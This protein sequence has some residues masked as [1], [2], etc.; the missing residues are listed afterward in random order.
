MRAARLTR[1]LI[2][3]ALF[4]GA[5][6]LRVY[7]LDAVPLRGDEAFSVRYWAVPPEE[8]VRTMI[9]RDHE[10][11]P[12][13]T[14]LTFWAWKYAA[15]QSPFAMR[16]LPAL[17]SLVGMAGAA[18]LARQLTRNDRVGWI[19]AALW[20]IHPFEIWHAQDVRNYAV[21]AGA[22]ALALA[23]FVRAVRRRQR[24]DWVF[25]VA[26]EWLALNTF[27]LEAF[28]LP[29]QAL[30]LLLFRRSRRVW[31]QAA[32][33]WAALGILLIPWSAQIATLTGSGYEGTAEK[34]DLSH[35]VTRFLPEL[36]IGSA[37]RAPWGILLS[38]AWIVVIA[39]LWLRGND[40]HRLGLWLAGAI[41]IPA[42]LLAVTATRMSVF[43]PRYVIP[44]I[45]ALLLLTAV[46][47]APDRQSMPARRDLSAARLALIALPV[48]CA[49]VLLPYYRGD[50]PKSPD[51]PA[52]T[53][54]LEERAMPRDLILQAAAD[55]AF[56]YYYHGPSD[57]TSLEPGVDVPVQLR[58][59]ITFYPAIWLVGRQL[60]AERV[61]M[62]AMQS[63]SF[64]THGDFAITQFRQRVPS[65]DEIA[66]PFDATFGAVARLRGITLQGPDR[67][68][69]ATTLLVFW[70][71]L[72]TTV[73]DYK[74]FV[75]L[76]GA[77]NPQTGGPLWDQDDHPPLYGD[78]GT[79]DWQPGTLY[80]DQYHLLVNPAVQLAPGTYTLEIGFYDPDTAERLPITSAD[81][82]PLG[83]SLPLAT[84]TWPPQ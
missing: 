24:R 31:R 58:D 37:P 79:R 3:A 59:K 19:V 54:Y 43:H 23:M 4:L 53:A 13:G 62:D 55:P 21:W 32:T 33:A 6:A 9:Q 82:T 65:L 66:T 22:S 7:R 48:L 56:G 49:V 45:P 78:P 17:V 74:V 67:F 80:R 47:F 72:A 71:P 39:W 81:G 18:A 57:E 15:G 64:D 51:W 10:P 35:L 25:Y 42:A 46:A 30:Y 16:C 52:L 84:I 2:F 60:D 5:F 63:I 77:P 44:V 12:M 14:F 75:H 28:F 73:A 34:T 61:L 38:L 26:A 69:R 1:L 83:D 76:T 70:E 68:A 40:S 29:A 11:H 20:A 8:A 36:L 50:D 41:L 27:F